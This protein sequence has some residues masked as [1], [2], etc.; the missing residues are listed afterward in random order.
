MRMDMAPLRAFLVSPDDAFVQQI[1][2]LWDSGAVRWSVFASAAPAVEQLFSD[3]PDLLVADAFLPDMPGETLVSLVKSENVYRQVPVVLR[4]PAGALA[5][6]PSSGPGGTGVD[7]PAT[8]IDDF[9]LPPFNAMEYRA[10]VELALTRMRRSLDANPLTRLPGN[11]TIIQYIKENI[12]K[13]RDFA[14]GYADLDNFKAFND[15][16]GFARGDEALMMTARIIVNTVRAVAGPLA[17]VGHVGGDDF[18]FGVPLDAAEAVCQRLVA[19]FDAIVPSFYD[20]Q[21]RECGG[22]QS[23]DRQGCPQ[24][25]PLM[26]ISIAVVCNRNGSLKHYAAASAIASQLKKKAKESPRSVYVIDRRGTE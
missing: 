4:L 8:D 9:L 24:R 13:Q 15:T 1:L 18:V 22:I 6:S 5:D 21:D 16:Y 14:L 26:A 7:W 19:S 25:F 11:A 10:R 17:F 12:D 20:A 2:A 23:V 3:P